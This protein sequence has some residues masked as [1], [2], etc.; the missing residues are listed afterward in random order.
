MAAGRRGVLEPKSVKLVTASAAKGQKAC[1]IAETGDSAT[2][3]LRMLKG[4]KE[5]WVGH[6]NWLGGIG[7]AGQTIQS[8]L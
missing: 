2:P 7:A 8:T 3:C 4:A 1:S 6:P 5:N